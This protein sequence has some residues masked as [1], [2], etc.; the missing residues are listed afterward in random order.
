M[1]FE[2]ADYDAVS[3]VDVD[4]ECAL[5]ALA[6]KASRAVGGAWSIDLLE[7]R[8]G[9][10]LTDMAEAHR[11]WHDW[12]DCPNRFKRGGDIIASAAP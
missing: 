1:V 9:W 11:S 10:V 12:P 3:C 6:E 7:T 2:N 4:E 8:R 5:I